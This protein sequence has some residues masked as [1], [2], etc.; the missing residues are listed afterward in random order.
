VVIVIFLQIPED[1]NIV[2]MTLVKTLQ[3][4][5][6]LGTFCFVPANI[7]L[8]LALQW[9]GNTYA[10]NTWRIILL[11]CISG[12]LFIIWGVIQSKK[13]DLATLPPRI[14]SQRS[15]AFGVWASFTIGAAT[16]VLTYFI[17]VWF[18]AIKGTSATQSGINYLP[19]P[20]SATVFSIIAGVGVRFS[21]IPFLTF[22]LM[23]VRQPGLATMFL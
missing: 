12:V 15:M 19:M 21:L 17:P 9:G 20:I 8:L 18:Q 4:F 5:D 14:I 16:F 6:I 13:A 10:W 7:C 1:A 3:Q 11:F 23:C 2:P 22:N